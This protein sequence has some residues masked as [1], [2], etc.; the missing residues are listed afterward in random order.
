MAATCTCKL[1]LKVIFYNL[2]L[3][4]VVNGGDLYK[5]PQSFRNFVKM[6]DIHCQY[7]CFF[8]YNIVEHSR[9]IPLTLDWVSN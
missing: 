9:D 1:S 5:D 4:M 3:D 6:S 7:A 2:L 8:I